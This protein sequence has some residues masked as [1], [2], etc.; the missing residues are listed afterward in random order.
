MKDSRDTGARAPP[1]IL[2]LSGTI[3]AHPPPITRERRRK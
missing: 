3:A 1:K 2:I